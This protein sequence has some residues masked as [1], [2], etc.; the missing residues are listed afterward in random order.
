MFLLRWY[1]RTNFWSSHWWFDHKFNFYKWSFL[2]HKESVGRSLFLLQWYQRTIIRTSHSIFAGQF[3]LYK[4]SVLI[5]KESFDRS[6]SSSGLDIRHF[7][8]MMTYAYTW[9]Y[10]IFRYC[11]WANLIDNGCMTN[12]DSRL[13]K[14]INS[15]VCMLPGKIIDMTLKHRER[16]SNCRDPSF[17]FDGSLEELR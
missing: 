8:N 13:S 4:W 3:K 12:I 7:W 15:I 16:E 17:I 9:I 10:F 2:I 14:H 6:L 5:Q 11:A 1:Q